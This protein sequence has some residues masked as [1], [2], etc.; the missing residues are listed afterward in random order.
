[1]ACVWGV[2]LKDPH[3]HALTHSSTWLFIFDTLHGYWG[4]D[5]ILRLP[6]GGGGGG[7]Y[8][9]IL[10]EAS[11]LL[12]LFHDLACWLRL[13]RRHQP[14]PRKH[15]LCLYHPSIAALKRSSQETPPPAITSLRWPQF[16]FTR[17]RWK[18]VVEYSISNHARSPYW[19]ISRSNL[20]SESN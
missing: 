19:M 10:R 15:Q 1:M 3:V 5:S 6:Q 9:S 17:R 18:E 13:S 2:R 4:P 7:V 16:F 11:M 12:L 20:F 8:R 14:E